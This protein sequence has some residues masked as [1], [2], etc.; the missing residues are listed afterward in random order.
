MKL[1]SIEDPAAAAKGE[2]R[3]I[4]PDKNFII[5][6]YGMMIT[7]TPSLPYM[8]G[9]ATKPDLLSAMISSRDTMLQNIGIL[10]VRINQLS[11]MIQEEEQKTF[12]GTPDPSDKSDSSDKSVSPENEKPADTPNAAGSPENNTSPAI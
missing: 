8:S 1:I 6:E 5:E 2:K 4:T 7:V 10:T 11:K 9:I 12:R 3:Y